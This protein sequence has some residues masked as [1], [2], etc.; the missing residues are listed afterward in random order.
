MTSHFIEVVAPTEDPLSKLWNVLSTREK[1][2]GVRDTISSNTSQKNL[3]YSL[4]FYFFLLPPQLQHMEVPGLGVESE[5]Q[6]QAYITA[7][8][9]PDPS[10]IFNLCLSLQQCRILNPVSEARD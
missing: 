1:Y 2:K 6:L 8:A 7:T 3:H 9:K 5:L 4:E 10:C